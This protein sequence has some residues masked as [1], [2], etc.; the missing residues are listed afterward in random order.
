MT[1]K[2][3]PWFLWLFVLF[4]AAGA[5]GLLVFSK[6]EVV[7]LVNE[8]HEPGWSLFFRYTTFLGD[9]LVI[10][11]AIV[12]LFLYKTGMAL[13]GLLAHALTGGIV[14]F[15]KKV[16][17]A[18]WVRPIRYFGEE[19]SLQLVE[20]V[21]V[22]ALYS[23]PSGHTATAFMF[24]CF[25]S[26][27]VPD[28]RWGILFFLLALAAGLSRIYLVQHFFMDVYFGAIAGV[29]VTAAVFYFLQ[30]SEYLQAQPWWNRPI[31]RLKNYSRNQR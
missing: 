25:L 2:A 29:A 28:K 15:C 3:N 16:V 17:F 5:V 23:F 26:L 4:L 18:E 24:F 11:I 20:G 12:M 22:N 8:N 21:R 6:G 9:G 19:Q 1:I 13:T 30:S 27:I 10:T 31:F 14:Q 7:L